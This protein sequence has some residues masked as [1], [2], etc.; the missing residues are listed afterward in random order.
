[1]D[2]VDAAAKAREVTLTTTGRKTGKPRSVTVWITTDGKR[3]YIRSGRGLRR[4]W[5]QNILVQDE[6][7]VRIGKDSFNVKARHVTDSDEAHATTELVRKKYRMLTSA[8]E[9]EKA[10]FELVPV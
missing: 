7:T 10:V 4:D 6:A 8:R 5:P 3:V 1:M 9:G 2:F